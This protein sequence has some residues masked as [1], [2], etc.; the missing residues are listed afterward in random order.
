M[1]SDDL[2][3]PLCKW[4][5]SLP[6]IP[7][8]EIHIAVWEKVCSVAS[9][10]LVQAAEK[11][12]TGDIQ[13]KHVKNIKVN[14]SPVTINSSMPLLNIDSNLKVAPTADVDKARL[15]Q[16]LSSPLLLPP[17][18]IKSRTLSLGS[19]HHKLGVG[20]FEPYIP[21]KKR[22]VSYSCPTSPICVKADPDRSTA[23]LASPSLSQ[24]FLTWQDIK[25][26]TKKTNADDLQSD[27][28]YSSPP[29]VS[30]CSSLCVSQSSI[31]AAVSDCVEDPHVDRADDKRDIDKSVSNMVED[32]FS[33]D[34][35]KLCE[36]NVFS[37]CQAKSGLLQDNTRQQISP[38]GLCHS[39]ELA[40]KLEE[41]L[42]DCLLENSRDFVHSDATKD[43]KK[44]KMADFE[45]LSDEQDQFIRDLLAV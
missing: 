10:P 15:T 42:P 17:A 26:Q 19:Q 35:T 22:L 18:T 16:P 40:N 32:T 24:P 45:K 41:L 38:R 36:S 33:C 29:S 12:T 31:G 39:T 37:S 25:E 11:T 23:P 3:S 2:K 20:K 14:C 5:A 1:E 43:G 28:G 13:E 8:S 4:S 44:L 7:P 6:A 30:S 27:S 9:S 34:I 21:R